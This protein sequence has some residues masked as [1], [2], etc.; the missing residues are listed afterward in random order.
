MVKD[1][2]TWLH[3]S[4]L[5]LR[6]SYD[7]DIVLGKLLEDIPNFIKNSSLILDF[8]I[9]SGDI[10][11]SSK[12]EEYA[13]AAEFL[14]RLLEITC[15]K[16]D[17]LFL[18]PG[19]HDIDRTAIS[20][21]AQCITENLKNR[22]VINNILANDIDRAFVLK[23]FHN[24]IQFIKD[25]M[26]N[27]I[28][29][30]E[31][32]Y[33]YVKDIEFNDFRIS[34]L[35]LN[36]VWLS[37]SDNDQ[38]KLAL[39]EIQIRNA[40]K[41]AEGTAMHI[42]IMHHPL[43]WL[44]DKGS[45]EA[46]LNKECEFIL[47][48]HLH[49]NSITQI[50]A[51]GRDSTIIGA[52]ACF[53][54]R[55][56]Q[57]SY[58]FVQLDLRR[59]NGTIYLRRYSDKDGGF[60]AKDTL[61]YSVA[62]DGKFI[63]PLSRRIFKISSDSD[64]NLSESPSCDFIV[65]NRLKSS[66]IGILNSKCELVGT[67]FNASRE[68]LIITSARAVKKA[69]SRP[70]D[71][72][73]ICFKSAI[74]KIHANVVENWWSDPNREDIAI[75]SIEGNVPV[76]L[77]PLEL[78]L[79]TGAIGHKISSFGYPNNGKFDGISG[80]GEI[81]GYADK[82]GRSLI[83]IAS[84]V[85]TSE[86]DGAPI[87]DNSSRQVIG[88]VKAISRNDSLGRLKVNAYA[89]SSEKLQKVCP[90]LTI[91]EPVD[92]GLKYE[93][94]L[95]LCNRQH[96]MEIES[97][98]IKYIKSIYVMRER[99]EGL[100]EEFISQFKIIKEENEEIRRYNEEEIRKY[101]EEDSIKNEK[102]SSRKKKLNLM[103]EKKVSNCLLFMGEAGIGKTNLLC[104]LAQKYEKYYPILFLTGGR[105]LLG[106]DYSISDKISDDIGNLIGKKS[107]Y[108][109]NELEIITRK[110]RKYLVVLIDAINES[111][112]LDLMRIHLGR[113]L[114]YSRDKNIAFVISCRDIDWRF[115]EE[116][117]LINASISS[118][119]IENQ[120]IKGI[121]LKL[122]ND[123]EFKKAWKLYKNHFRLKG[124]IEE[125]IKE[126]CKQ[127]IMLRFF[128]EAYEGESVPSKDVR[129]IQIFN[130]YWDRKLSGTKERR[131]SQEFLFKL[132]SKMIQ[133]MRVD[134]LEFE[135][136]TITT[137]KADK[138]DTI[139]SKV[140]S[141]DIIIYRDSDKI[142]GEKKIGFTYEAFFE[143]IIAMYFLRNIGFHGEEQLINE[144]LILLE[145]V[146]DYRN[147]L[148]AI[149]YIILLLEERNEKIYIKL[150]EI[151]SEYKNYRKETL[152][153]IEKLKKIEGSEMA[154][155]ILSDDERRE[156]NEGVYK[157]FIN[158]LHNFS[159]DSQ[160]E[161]F[162]NL[163]TKGDKIS[164]EFPI[165]YIIRNY[166]KLPFELKFLLLKFS[167]CK[168]I[169]T[170]YNLSK[171]LREMTFSD[172]PL[173]IPVY[174]MYYLIS[175][176]SVTKD[177]NILTELISLI[178]TIFLDLSEAKRETL[179]ANI[180][181]NQWT[182]INRFDELFKEYYSSMSRNEIRKTFFYY[183]YHEN[184]YARQKLIYH[185]KNL[186]LIDIFS[187]QELIEMMKSLWYDLDDE[188]RILA[189]LHFKD[190]SIYFL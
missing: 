118:K 154:V 138:P 148:G 132:V 65:S 54:R 78:G 179:M 162:E 120:T 59:G 75:L 62:Q 71:K 60:W 157:I 176:L 139:F 136:E 181:N 149:E 130:K 143:F 3:I 119:Y 129:R 105:T 168:Y 66:I 161:I 100:F 26:G 2:I 5:H 98:G 72:I 49:D 102:K 170:K 103:D 165:S 146:K 111:N 29:F 147:F 183:T 164:Q 31:T 17:R 9:L 113:I 173:N 117:Q 14:D 114:A 92:L 33:Y 169:K 89:I 152:G 52:G 101:N 24:Y 22:D 64:M 140:L 80:G 189:R 37:S 112:N 188:V 109:L 86:F 15:L 57:N 88:M 51:P 82:D 19:N 167:K 126:I 35:G 20:P 96:K 25:Y 93:D 182:D 160:E 150:L 12:P 46:I 116:D 187:Q 133:E 21:G 18:I 174:V 166:S 137:Q 127:P 28:V 23:R 8:I 55:T 131:E 145:K 32:N 121:E 42:A 172:T 53:E 69:G 36:S 48:G 108:T 151:L 184:A 171:L 99:T 156:I 79:S 44:S 186:N 141:E 74:N 107:V 91:K 177:K 45:V 87:W 4:D 13:L 7:A 38:G 122:F 104:Y 142:T 16:K 190:K 159:I 39:G 70:G 163:S 47:H 40:L 43:D 56:T 95:N 85:I 178:S 185:I 125:D 175:N 97:I 155:E 63:F 158:N 84:D 153:L 6:S 67:G 61:T 58:N 124:S 135:V 134:L 73:E 144:F 180:L 90:K 76:G 68:G 94:L 106:I 110:A 11:H 50:C 83:Q 115:F 34:I 128:A 41:Q 10:S 27:N 77:I 30:D 81:I 1:K 123:N